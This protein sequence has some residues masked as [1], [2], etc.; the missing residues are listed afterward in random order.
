MYF[1]A[2]IQQ[3]NNKD[4]RSLPFAIWF[5]FKLKRIETKDLLKLWLL[6]NIRLVT[7]S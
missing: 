7:A 1:N 2:L 3:L 6:F 4:F 5:T